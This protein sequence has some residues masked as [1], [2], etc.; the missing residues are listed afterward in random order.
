MM[1]HRDLCVAELPF[2][3]WSAPPPLLHPPATG[4]LCADGPRR[5]RARVAAAAAGDSMLY[6]HVNVR[7][8]T[9]MCLCGS[10]QPERQLSSRRGR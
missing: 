9:R 7:P 10:S 3:R 5:L 4:H 1:L 2:G 8:H 6:E